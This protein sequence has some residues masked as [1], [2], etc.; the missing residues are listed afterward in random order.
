M[1]DANAKLDP[2]IQKGLI[3]FIK[4][5][6]GLLGAKHFKDEVKK[7]SCEPCKTI[8]AIL[9]VLLFCLSAF[10]Q[11]PNKTLTPGVVRTTNAAEI[12][13]PNFRTKPYRLT[14]P[15]MKHQVCKAYKI[16]A[17]C[18][19]PTGA[20]EIDHLVPLELGGLDT[21]ENLWPELANYPLGPG[22]HTKDKLENELKKR[23]CTGQMTLA[24]AQ[25]CIRDQWIEC[26]QRVFP[27]AKP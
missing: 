8:L 10:A 9:G 7:C 27:P 25:S 1:A 14:T 12:C 2:V 4:K 13:A 24:D 16:T 11:L 3:S 5:R 23:V 17:Q 18:P 19:S 20:M 26:Y 21:V 22:F 15:A 6:L